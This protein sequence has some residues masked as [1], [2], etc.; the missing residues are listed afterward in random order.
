MKQSLKI[1]FVA[2]IALFSFSQM[3]SAQNDYAD[4]L[5]SCNVTI[6]AANY[7]TIG[8]VRRGT[9]ISHLRKFSYSRPHLKKLQYFMKLK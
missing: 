9:V 7:S 2:L 8:H 6:E 3:A 1:S 5:K 4:E